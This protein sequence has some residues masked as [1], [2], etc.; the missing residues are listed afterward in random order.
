MRICASRNF[1]GMHRK[2]ISTFC[3]PQ[4]GC[5][6]EISIFE[7][8]GDD[9]LTGLYVEPVSGN[10]Y[11]VYG[12]VP[13]FLP[14]A[15]PAE[16]ID[17]YGDRLKSLAQQYPGLKVE[18]GYV[19]TRWSFSL[20]WE[21]HTERQMDSTWGMSTQSRY[22]QFLL[23][24]GIDE[25]EIDGI[26]ILDAGCGNGLLTEYI[27]EQGG[28]VFGVDFSTSVFAAERR[29]TSPNCCFLQ[30]DL[31]QL[32]FR[33]GT[34]QVIISNGVIHHTPDPEKTFRRVAEK[35]AE[36][37]RFYVWLYSRKGSHAWR[38]KRRV[39]DGLR[40]GF[41]RAPVPVQ[42][43]G[44]QSVTALLY[45]AY[46]LAGKQ[47]DRDTLQ[48]NIYDSITPRWR[49]YHTPEEVSRWYYEQGFGPVTLTHWDNRYGFGVVATRQH[50][51]QTPGEHYVA[52]SSSPALD[53]QICEHR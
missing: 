42:K 11:A 8:V 31:Q 34:F 47:L 22:E 21:T 6:L 4:N 50:M 37:G 39:F 14:R 9:I 10:A 29:R 36:G 45:G 2:F 18:A 13:I 15:I 43:V 48:V 16:F 25:D 35:V 5:D 17:Q 19:N 40:M 26:K 27:A 3:D 49:H 24:T 20:E 53:R 12:G 52:H 41:S 51:E 33:S 23:E 44:V 46:R 32:P 30:C 38:L 1:T 7:E 28:I